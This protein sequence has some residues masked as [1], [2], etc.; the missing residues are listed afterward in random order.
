[1][2]I[3]IKSGIIWQN[4][5]G[6]RVT[7]QRY[8][9]NEK[10]IRSAFFGAKTGAKVAEL[11]KASGVS[12][13]TIYRHHKGM[14]AVMPDVE[15]EVLAEFDE[16]VAKIQGHKRV[17]VRVMYYKMLTFIYRNRQEFALIVKKGDERTLEEMVVELLPRVVRN[18]K[19]PAQYD[20]VIRIYEKE[21]IA[22]VETWIIDGFSTSEM[23]VL[24][25]IMYLTHSVRG[26]LMKIGR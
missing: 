10:A 9:R 4:M 3:L 1:M 19:I 6:T 13:A 11:A 26:R 12:R 24:K 18:F 5:I 17:Y 7:D 16:E 23:G 8:Q 2:T 25:D 20:E 15:Q 22:V 14:Q 21:V